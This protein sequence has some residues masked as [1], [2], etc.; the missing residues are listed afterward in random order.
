[1]DRQEQIV[2]VD[3][4]SHAMRVLVTGS[5]GYMGHQIVS[6]LA[7]NGWKVIGSTRRPYS[8]DGVDIA[9]GGLLKT[10]FVGMIIERS[11]VVMH[12]AACTRGRRA[13]VFSRDN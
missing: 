2:W 5:N 9:C 4:V 11:D 1:M 10:D 7:R 3:R 13:E 8:L 12:C 6:R